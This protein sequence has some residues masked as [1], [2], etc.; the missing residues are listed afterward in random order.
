MTYSQLALSMVGAGG[1]SLIAAVAVFIRQRRIVEVLPASD[2]TVQLPTTWN[3]GEISR[4]LQRHQE[5]PK[6]LAHVVSSIKSRMILNQDLHTAQHRL[7]LMTSVIE[8]FKANQQLH[9]ILHELHLE[10]KEFEIKKIEAQIRKEDAQ[11]R[12]GS[13]PQ[14]RALRK[15][16]DELQIKKE[17]AQLQ[18]DIKEVDK[19]QEVVP[20]VLT[21]DQQRRMKR[22][23]IED[24]MRELDRLEEAALKDARDE[25]EQTRIRNMHADKKQELREQLSRFLV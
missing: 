7:K 17:V 4:V 10:E 14:L 2:V 15:Q 16:R 25:G 11:A 20:P 23:E 1:V 22:M 12:L 8:V 6:V 21:A 18:R 9:G 3:D 13:E 24:K 5:Q 19:T